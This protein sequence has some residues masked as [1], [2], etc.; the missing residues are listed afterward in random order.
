MVFWRWS[1]S[2]A[3]PGT[4]PLGD[5]GANTSPPPL[6]PAVVGERW[7]EKISRHPNA[8]LLSKSPLWSLTAVGAVST[9][10]GTVWDFLSSH[11]WAL[12]RVLCSVSCHLGI[13]ATLHTSPSS[14]T[15]TSQ[16]QKREKRNKNQPNQQP[17]KHH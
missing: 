1:R 5:D 13:A 4:V 15:G 9:E 12:W 3:A 11:V 6:E 2:K 17:K 7:K 16:I 10:I 14:H 8:K